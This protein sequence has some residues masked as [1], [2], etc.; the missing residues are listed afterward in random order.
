[1]SSILHNTTSVDLV[2]IDYDVNDCVQYS[3]VDKNKTEELNSITEVI[4]RRI[5]EM[6]SKPAIIYLNVAINHR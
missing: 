2:I 4:I 1:L 6:E 3:D 5:L